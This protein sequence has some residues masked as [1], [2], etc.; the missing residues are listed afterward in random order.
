MSYSAEI[1][2]TNPSCFLFLI[3]QSTSME[4]PWGGEQD[5]CKAEGVADAINRLLQTLVLRCAKAEGI[6]DY[7][8]VGVIGYGQ[9][10]HPLLG[11]ASAPV[12]E[13]RPNQAASFL[14][15]PGRT[16]LVP[17]SVIAQ[18][19]LRI[20]ERSKFVPDGAGGVLSQKIKF[21]V[22]FEP[23]AD[24]PT[25]MCEALNLA[26]HM[27]ADFLGRYSNCYPPIV[28]N[29]TDGEST[30]GDPE[31]HAQ[32]LKDMASTDGSALLFNLHLSSRS[33]QPVVF[34][35][36]EDGL[37]D[38][39]ARLL[40]RMSSVLPPVLGRTAQRDGFHVSDQSHGF[41]FNADLV[42][43]IRFL[44]IGTRVDAKNL[45]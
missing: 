36:H 43:V 37:P 4:D 41:A 21:P 2:R 40:F 12:L 17:V 11:S 25:P 42:S 1:S 32:C 44:D 30:D 8:H 15:A 13:D 28:F 9:Q 34:P 23:T 20:E 33:E 39:F 18:A 35:D 27:L 26:W 16:G 29:I 24:G 14:A 45:R 31:A 10:V 6:R 19:P 38:G 3:D 22:W 7:F 5:K